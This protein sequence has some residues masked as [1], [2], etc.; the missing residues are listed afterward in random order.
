M[1]P[2]QAEGIAVGTLGP[3]L[4]AARMPLSAAAVAAGSG[5]IRSLK[6]QQV[7]IADVQDAGVAAT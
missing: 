1:T 7:L 6:L 4:S 5:D 2:E 3:P